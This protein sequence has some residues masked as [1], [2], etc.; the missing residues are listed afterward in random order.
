[1]DSAFGDN[2][3]NRALVSLFIYTVVKAG[4]MVALDMA[5]Y[6]KMLLVDNGLNVTISKTDDGYILVRAVPMEE[7]MEQDN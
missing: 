1:M 5:D 7:S 3:L 2:D 6:S 4:G